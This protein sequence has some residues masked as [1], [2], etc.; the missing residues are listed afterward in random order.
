M[1]RACRACRC[2]DPVEGTG[3]PAPP[4]PPDPPG[5]LATQ[6]STFWAHP[7]WRPVQ[8]GC[9]QGSVGLG[10]CPRSR[11]VPEAGCPVTYGLSASHVGVF[12]KLVTSERMLHIN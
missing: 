2:R 11:A 8:D 10:G 3:F 5:S 4:A 9:G 1:N 7:A 6:V 12:A